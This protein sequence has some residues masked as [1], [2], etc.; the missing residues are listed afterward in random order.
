[1]SSDLQ[2][3]GKLRASVEDYAAQGLI[4]KKLAIIQL[5]V[6]IDLDEKAL[7]VEEPNR[8]LLEPLFA[9]L[10]FRTLGR[11]VFGDDFNTVEVASRGGGGQMDL[12]AADIVENTAPG[13]ETEEPV[14]P[15][16]N[17]HNTPHTYRSVDTPHAAQPPARRLGKF[18]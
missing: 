17:I 14:V 2:L 18:T 7:E 15:S 1:C 4:S 12:F 9:E 8:G 6:P 16:R 11:R 5:D 13:V 3:K 10:E